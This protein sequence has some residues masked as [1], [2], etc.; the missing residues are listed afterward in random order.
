LQSQ[1]AKLQAKMATKLKGDIVDFEACG[2]CHSVH[3]QVVA[4]G[5]D[6]LFVEEQKRI[7]GGLEVSLVNEVV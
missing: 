5:V 6:G 3:V 2:Y 1:I 4:S 7:F